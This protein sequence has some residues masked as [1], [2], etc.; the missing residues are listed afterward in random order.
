MATISDK[1]IAFFDL[2]NRSSSIVQE[3]GAGVT[4]FLTMSYILLVNP[5][6]LSNVGIQP[7]DIGEA[8]ILNLSIYHP[9]YV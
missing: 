4:C 5:Q 8:L 7:T 6:V 2:K 3:V 1:I 9:P